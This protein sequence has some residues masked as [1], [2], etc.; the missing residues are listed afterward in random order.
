MRWNGSKALVAIAV[1]AALALAGCSAGSG[2]VGSSS[3]Q[4]ASSSGGSSGSQSASGAPS[5]TASSAASSG[6]A[7]SS[8]ASSSSSGGSTAGTC[9]S[10]VGGKPSPPA[11]VPAATNKSITLGLILAPTSLDFTTDNG[12]AIPQALLGNV[13]ETLVTQDQNT[14]AIIGDLAKCWTVSPDGKTYT[15]QLQPNATFSNG[16]K[17]TADTAAYSI[18]YVKTKWTNALDA[19]M[20]IVSSATAV[21]PT[22]LKVELSSPSNSWLFNM[23]T[24]VGAMMDPN[25]IA[26]IKTKPI[27]TGPYTFTSWTPGSTGSL[28]LTRN[29]NYWGAKAPL[30]KVTFQ[31]YSDPSAMNNAFLTGQIQVIT[32]VQTPQTLGQFK[33]NPKYTVIDGSTTG[34]VMMT[35]NNAKPPLNNIKVRQAINYALDKQAILQGAWGGYGQVIGSHEVPTDPWYVDLANYYPHDVA[36]AKQLLA[37]A[38]QSNLHLTLTLPPVPY[39]AAAAPIIVSELAQAGITVTTTNV[40]FNVWLAK[41]FAKPFDYDLTI[42]NHVEARDVTTVFDGTD[43]YYTQYVNPKVT[44]LEKEGDAGT[45]AQYIQDYKEVMKI[46]AQDAAAA[47]LWA[48]PNLMVVDS[49]VHGLPKNAISEYLDVSK[50]SIS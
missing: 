31:Y 16:D 9:V 5:S 34:K 38:G 19:K 50:I 42:I 46:L 15:F 18:N 48:F 17:F 26:T 41:V 23:T 20:K 6:G 33:N 27:G 7:S 49:N 30:Q 36:K 4:P 21:S 28:V 37:E 22:E 8:A 10:S 32:T 43:D 47:W 12:A 39:A 29:E 3:G 14:G 11:A 2:S 25:A 1:T 45:P 44:Q 24:A 13:Y 35:I 40:T